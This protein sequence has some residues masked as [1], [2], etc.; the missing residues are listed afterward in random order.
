MTELLDTTEILEL[1]PQPTVAVRVQQPMKDLDLS[2]AF[3]R[4]MPLVAERVVAEGGAIAGPPFGRY[5][6]Y[7]PDIVDVEIGFPVVTLPSGLPQLS[8]TAAGEIGTSELPGGAVARTIHRGS[9]DGLAG[10]YDALHTWIHAQEGY[11]DGDGPWESYVEMPSDV[12]E[13]ARSRTE[14]YWPLVRT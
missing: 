10:T 14:I 3:D 6:R 8:S 7:G 11:D 13:P 4:F 5:H 9:Y 1:E 2:S 12:P